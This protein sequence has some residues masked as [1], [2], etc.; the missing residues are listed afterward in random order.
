MSEHAFE[1]VKTG[2][3]KFLQ[4]AF[5]GLFFFGCQCAW[6]QQ[7]PE[8]VLEVGEER[9]LRYEL[10]ESVKSLLPPSSFHGELSKATQNKY[11][12]QAIERLTERALLYRAAVQA[13]IKPDEGLLAQAEQSNVH[14]FGSKEEFIKQLNKSGLTKERF[15]HRVIAQ[16]VITRYVNETLTPKAVYTDK[17]LRE[18]FKSNPKEFERPETVGAW[19]IILK[20]QPNAPDEEWQKKQ[21]L[22]DSLV[23]QIREGAE[24]TDI[25]SKHSED[26]YRVKGGWIGDMHKGRLLQELEDALFKLKEGEMAGPIRS[27]HGFHIVKAGKRQSAGSLSFKEAR[28]KLKKRLE[29]KRFEEL[30]NKAMDEQRKQVKIKVLINLDKKA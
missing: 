7:A 16:N 10:D 17:Q 20:V 23:K 28:D 25:A 14:R 24:F 12:K 8:V 13:G 30:R 29:E 3:R 5:V 6:A 18:Y 2:V 9:F 27:L 22:A 26:D 4:L 11:T 15:E 21:A 1:P 19:H